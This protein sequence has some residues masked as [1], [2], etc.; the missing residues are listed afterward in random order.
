MKRRPI[1][2]KISRKLFKRGTKVHKKNA[3]RGAGLSGIMRGGI[4]F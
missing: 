1:S 3:L 2:N 4:R